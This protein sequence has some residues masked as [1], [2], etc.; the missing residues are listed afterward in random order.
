MARPSLSLRIIPRF[1]ARIQGT[2]GIAVERSG[3]VV[4]LSQDWAAIQEEVTPGD[5][6]NYEFLLRNSEDGALIRLNAT[7]LGALRPIA[8]EPEA[9]AG[10][11][12]TKTMTPLRTKQ[13]IDARLADDT[14][15][16]TDSEKLSTPEDVVRR[17][18][19]TDVN[20]QSSVAGNASKFWTEYF[21]NPGTGRVH[22]FNRIFA[23]VAAGAS[24]DR[25]LTTSTWVEDYFQLITDS[26]FASVSAIGSLAVTGVSRTSDYSAWTGAAAGGAQGVSGF[27]V[28]DDTAHSGVAC[29]VYGEAI[30]KADVQGITESCELTISSGEP[31]EDIN[32]YSGVTSK[33]TFALNLT[34][35]FRP[36]YNEDISCAFIFGGNHNGVKFRKGFVAILDGLDASVGS[37]GGGVL[38]DLA[39]GTSLR[40]VDAAGVVKGEIWAD[41]DGFQLKDVG[42]KAWTP[43]VTAGSGTITSQTTVARYKKIGNTLHFN[44]NITIATNGTAAGSVS[45]TLPFTPTYN[46]IAFG[47][48]GA[49]TG[50]ALQCIMSAFN[51]AATVLD[52]SN[53]YPGGD[54]HRLNLTGTVEV[55]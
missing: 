51:S 52:V 27:A 49:V 26:Q 36:E 53:A 45:F 50:A 44:V 42:W 29:A 18:Q 9:E 21:G 39:L 47:R 55:Q 43:T 17:I 4:T 37:G 19:A 33:T 5:P 41:T 16:D 22:R 23:G 38:G 35:G 3:G 15:P 10:A 30:H 11:D 24:S 46:T 14:T 40:W 48:E 8:S 7:E 6:E 20:D 2:D 25:P 13:Q 32:P 31:V 12:N 28:N 54:G 1:P 34:A